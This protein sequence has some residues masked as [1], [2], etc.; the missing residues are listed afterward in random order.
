MRATKVPPR[1]ETLAK[2]PDAMV[3]ESQFRAIGCG[4]CHVRVRASQ[5]QETVRRKHVIESSADRCAFS[6]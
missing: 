6:S 3:G 5:S 1:G 4:A 2:S